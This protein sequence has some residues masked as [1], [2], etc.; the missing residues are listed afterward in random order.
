[1]RIFL[2]LFALLLMVV[3]SSPAAGQVK[4]EPV[5]RG[6]KAGAGP[7]KSTSTIS[8]TLWRL[9][10][11][12]TGRLAQ[13][14]SAQQPA[15][16]VLR[17]YLQVYSGNVLVDIT[18]SGSAI[19]AQAAL[20]KTGFVL[21][22][23]YGR[24]ISGMLPVA[25][26]PQL[27][28]TP[29]I[30]FVNPAYRPLREPLHGG[31][32]AGPKK[33]KKNLPAMVISQGDTAQLSYLARLESRVTGKGVKVGILSDSY[34]NL[35]TAADGVSAG[36]LPGK[37]NPL[38]YKKAVDIIKDLPG[39]TGTDEGRAM[40]E[41]V[42]DVAPEAE[43][44]FHTAFLGQAD[45]AQGITDLVN[46]D[47]RVIADDAMYLDEPFFQDGIIAQSVN[48]AKDRGVCYFSAAGNYANLSYESDYR[49]TADEP[50]GPGFGTAHNFSGPG[51]YPR[52]FQPVFIPPGGTF[53]ISFQWDQPFFSAGGAGCTDDLDIY[54]L[55]E[56]GTIVAAGNSDNI[57]SGDALELLGYQNVSPGS[58]FFLVILKTAGPD[59]TRVKYNL[60]GNGQFYVSDAF[61]IPGLFAPTL[62]GHAKAA[63]AITTAAAFYL[64][65]PPYGV[66]PPVVEYFSS[67]GGVADYFDPTGNRI[68]PTIRKKPDVTAPDGG[69][70]SFFDPF[71][72]GD[73][74]QDADNYAN[75]F[76]TSAA[77]P[78]AAGVAALMLDAE[79]H[80]NLT[81]DQLRGILSASAT[82]MDNPDTPGFDNG[83]DFST[84]YGLINARAAVH[85]V[86]FPALY[87]KNLVLEAV[88]SV[89]PRQ[90]RR[91]K[92]T[93]PNPFAVE[94]HWLFPGTRQYG[95][96]TAAAGVTYFSTNP[97]KS[98]G[99]PAC[100]FM[101]LDWQDNFGFPRLDVINANSRACGGASSRTLEAEAAAAPSAAPL[102]AEVFPN[103]STDAFRL[104][105]SLAADDPADV[106]LFT[107]D[108][109]LLM[110][111]KLPQAKGIYAIDGKGYRPGI[112]L[113]RVRQGNFTKTLRVI[114]R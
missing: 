54:L 84:G 11:S 92:I 111:K 38:K 68:T 31:R 6:V 76:G 7:V 27:D 88:C 72:N 10:A 66:N 33:D 8:N 86:K 104:Y 74:I 48:R 50:L 12:F 14:N 37:D 17:K 13:D 21:Q 93:N 61:P 105:L 28:N 62:V 95:A 53:I 94:T 67:L 19:A 51:S 83:F 40:A 57:R 113:L 15:G 114:K 45:F 98:A 63:G 23:T 20:A 47:C 9:Y 42:H 39:T 81:P 3:V 99:A 4:G 103:P 109:K 90:E 22:A 106:A 58:T 65:T 26:L 82:D 24:I 46:K 25:S 101:I 80:H 96:I 34:D 35:G 2:L 5:F 55:D 56:T 91:W 85:A 110:T 49:G 89:D 71:G 70:T 77:V 112:Y 69:N 18:V 52:E 87:I 59:P 108:G 44:A 30:R 97:P 41:I 1:M 102:L 78:H 79:K 64:N 29:A 60:Y 107:A 16:D 32:A 73:I 36:E 75:F 43:L 100:N